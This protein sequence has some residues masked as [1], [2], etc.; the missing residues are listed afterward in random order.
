MKNLKFP[1]ALFIIIILLFSSS[2][3]MAEDLNLTGCNNQDTLIRYKDGTYE[4]HSRA[5]YVDEPYWGSVQITLKN[6]SF[7]SIIFTIRDSALHEPFNENYEKH[8][9]GN[10]VYIQQSRNDWKGVQTYPRKLSESQDINKVD[11]IS[12]ATWSF[13][14][15]K[16]SLNEAMKNAR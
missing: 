8:F 10:P 16:A 6:G 11:A 9:Q 5:T 12:G 7:T 1:H 4:G 13:N 15:F 2:F 3:C 14:I